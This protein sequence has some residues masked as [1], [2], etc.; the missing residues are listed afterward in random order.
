MQEA[1]LT[2]RLIFPRD[3]AGEIIRWKGKIEQAEEIRELR[4]YHRVV[5]HACI[6]HVIKALRKAI[7][8]THWRD[9]GFICVQCFKLLWDLVGSRS[10]VSIRFFSPGSDTGIIYKVGEM[11]KCRC[12]IRGR[13]ECLENGKCSFYKS[14]SI[15]SGSE[16]KVFPKNQK[17][18]TYLEMWDEEKRQRELEGMR[19]L[20]NRESEMFAW[21]EAFN[22][23]Y[24]EIKAAKKN[25]KENGKQE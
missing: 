4:P 6:H 15:K 17:K 10:K 11:P 20:S 9:K 25:S 18:I 19:Q 23:A 21:F 24:E 22:Y 14:G 3:I 13:M 12:V 5:Y 8:K 7:Q 1:Y 16:I 2:L